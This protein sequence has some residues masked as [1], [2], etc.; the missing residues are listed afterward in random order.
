MPENT[1]CY[2]FACVLNG[3]FLILQTEIRCPSL[4]DPKHVAVSD[5]GNRLGDTCQ[6]NCADGYILDRGNS[7]RTCQDSGKWDGRDPSCSRMLL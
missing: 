7:L 1:N 3:T 2:E 5:C 6:Y 4:K